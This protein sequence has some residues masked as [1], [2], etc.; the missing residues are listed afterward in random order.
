MILEHSVYIVFLLK[1]PG[2]IDSRHL[3]NIFNK[4]MDIVRA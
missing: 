1:A 2:P 4:W 3:T